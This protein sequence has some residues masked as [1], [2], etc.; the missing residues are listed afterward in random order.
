MHTRLKQK[1]TRAQRAVRILSGAVR[2]LSTFQPVLVRVRKRLHLFNRALNDFVV[3]M[4][5]NVVEHLASVLRGCVRRCFYMCYILITRHYLA[6]T[7][8]TCTS[9]IVGSGRKGQ[10]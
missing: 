2:I 7:R 4:L 5:G 10:S 1:T 3:E 6:Y 9:T 8:A